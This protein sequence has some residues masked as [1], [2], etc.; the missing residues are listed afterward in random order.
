MRP[1]RGLLM[2][3]AG[4]GAGGLAIALVYG[5]KD[6][7]LMALFMLGSG[8]PVIAG[9][10]L[11]ARRRASAGTLSCQLAAGIGMT[12]V[13]VALGVGAV[14]L[15]MFLSPH[16]AFIMA[17]LLVFAGTLTAYSLSVLSRGVLA[18]IGA[19]RDTVRAVGEGRRDVEI[20]TNARD[21]IA[22]LAG[23][24]NLMAAQ[25]AE[26][27][28]ERDTAESARKDLIAAVSHDLRTPL[29][30]LR[31]LA[32]AIEDDLVDRETRRRYHAQM[33]VHIGSLSALIEDLFE[34]SRLE[35]GDIQWSVQ[36]VAL[37][38]LV[39]ETVEAMRPHA[40]EKRVAVEA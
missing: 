6:G 25:L 16:D 40:R 1:W 23:A 9:A 17:L 29:T 20:S 8:A 34:L 27:E 19:V 31:L 5:T 24:A 38:E 32:D 37:D 39:E 3:A 15:L 30:S 26:R 12:V 35:A 18:D 10:H 7:T 36:Q 22:Q 4:A 33:S 21:E 13:L 2:L 14:A 11:L 28:A